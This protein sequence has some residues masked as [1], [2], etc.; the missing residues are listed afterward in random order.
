MSDLTFLTHAYAL[1]SAG[2]LWQPEVGDE[3][4]EREKPDQVSILINSAGYT[5]SD[6][7]EMYLWLPRLEQLVIQIEMR[8]AI[9]CHAGLELSEKKMFYRAVLK[10][11]CGQIEGQDRSLRGAI[12]KSLRELILVDTS[13]LH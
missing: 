4:A 12:A 8:Q 9:L 7:R 3:V 1:E 5:P 10:A 2:L 13:T 6:L 11:H